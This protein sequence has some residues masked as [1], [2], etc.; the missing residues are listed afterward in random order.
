MTAGCGGDDDEDDGLLGGKR[1]GQGQG[2][3]DATGSG[4]A[5]S[6]PRPVRGGPLR[7]VAVA[8]ERPGACAAESATSFTD[9]ASGSCLTVASGDGGADG[10]RVTGTLSSEASYD[11]ENGSGWT[12][13]IKLTSGDAKRFADLT[14]RL[15]GRTPPANRLAVVRGNELLSAPSVATAITGGEV[16][17]SGGFTRESAER[18]AR[19]LGG[20]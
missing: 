15:A 12:V 3:P 14:G 4:P 7:F 1:P 9:E 17:I 5:P 11:A 2:Q 10:M 19:D 6:T 16:Q 18:L 8:Q 13:K 20:G